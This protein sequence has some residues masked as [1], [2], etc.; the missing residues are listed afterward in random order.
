MISKTLQLHGIIEKEVTLSKEAPAHQI[1]SLDKFDA[2]ISSYDLGEDTAKTPPD[3]LA[4]AMLKHHQVLLAYCVDYALLPMRFGSIFSGSDAIGEAMSK[5]TVSLIRALD[6]LSN[7]R[8]YSIELL[9]EPLPKSPPA[10]SQ[11]GR[12]F[13]NRRMKARNQR[14]NIS[15]DRRE[16]ANGVQA[17]VSKLVGKNLGIG[18]SNSEK[19]LNL[20]TILS[21]NDLHLFRELALD[22]QAE[23]R[24]FGVSLKV[25]GPWP[26]YHFDT[27]QFENCEQFHDA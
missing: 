11:T 19:L 1:I 9:T 25:M 27:F 21:P 2:I 5:Q 12:A 14:R 7:H 4:A 3:E 17:R 6:T 20:T 18:A 24:A 10:Q 23:A 22:I 26:A 16:F 8:E 13:L 15:A